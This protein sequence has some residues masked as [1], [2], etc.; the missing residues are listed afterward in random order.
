MEKESQPLAVNQI[1]MH[2]SRK[3]FSTTVLSFPGVSVP[4]RLTLAS[5]ATTQPQRTGSSYKVKEESELSQ[6]ANVSTS[7]IVCG[8]LLVLFIVI[9]IAKWVTS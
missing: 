6:A 8:V 4:T 2:S 1:P 3:H 9:V 7:T 5:H